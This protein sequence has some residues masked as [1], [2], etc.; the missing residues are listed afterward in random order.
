MNTLFL[1][2][3][4]RCELIFLNAT[5]YKAINIIIETYEMGFGKQFFSS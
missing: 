4:F 2:P 3:D 5:V 1:I